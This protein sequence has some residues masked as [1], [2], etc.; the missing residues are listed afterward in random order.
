[1][2]TSYIIVTKF[3]GL[4]FFI[5]SSCGIIGSQIL[6]H[7][8]INTS[9]HLICHILCNH[10]ISIESII[11]IRV[12]R[13][14]DQII[15]VRITHWE[16]K[17]TAIIRNFNEERNN[18]IFNTTVSLPTLTN[19]FRFLFVLQNTGSPAENIFRAVSFNIH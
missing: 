2:L 5:E 9:I 11:L 12:S 7:L 3:T 13:N 14:R 17:I 18:A 10:E 8:A 15:T 16:N 1:M 19:T 6:F 4:I